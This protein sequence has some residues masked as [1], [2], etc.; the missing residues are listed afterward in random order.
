MAS[1]ATTEKRAGE[2]V[3]VPPWVNRLMA[4]IVR[5]PFRRFVDRSILLLTVTGTRS[6]RRY[7]FPVQY[8][9]EGD[10]LWVMTG[11]ASEKRWWKNLRSPAPVEIVLR[12]R[13]VPAIAIAVTREADPETVDAGVRRYVERFP[14]MAEKVGLPTDDPATA[15]RT[16]ADT[17]M[18]RITPAT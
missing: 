18:V 11:H 17:V 5:S 9:E 14:K 16:A 4:W 12:G 15:A 8:I 1:S 13:T 6:G 7:S 2:A 3:R 10:D